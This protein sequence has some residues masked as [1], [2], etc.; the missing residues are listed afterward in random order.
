MVNDVLNFVRLE[1]G[2]A[3]FAITDVDVADALSAAVDMVAPQLHAQ[4]LTF[5]Q[6]YTPGLHVRTDREKLQQIALNLLSNA[7]KYTQPGGHV[8][9][10]SELRDGAVHIQVR[11]NGRGIPKEKLENI[12]EPFVRLDLGLTRT[13]Q[14]TGLGL[15]ISR[16]LAR[17]LTGEL[18]A[19]S[20]LGLGSTFTL[21]L[22]AAVTVALAP[23]PQTELAATHAAPRG[24]ESSRH[25]FR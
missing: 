17:A 2:H 19:E 12:F 11:D 3:R 6:S 20:E 18:A 5:E 22:P 24:T 25:D 9:L 7:I 10:R 8:V 16:D 1:A 15:S 4:G 14:G 23:D 13:T 21:V